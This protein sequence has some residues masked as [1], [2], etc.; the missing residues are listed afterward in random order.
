M[1]AGHPPGPIPPGQDSAS[2]GFRHAGHAPAPAGARPDLFVMRKHLFSQAAPSAGGAHEAQQEPAVCR[3]P[4]GHS[5]ANARPGLAATGRA[6]GP[7]GLPRFPV[8]APTGNR[9][10][11]T[12]A[13]PE[14]QNTRKPAEPQ[15]ADTPET[16]VFA[17]ATTPWPQPDR[18]PAQRSPLCGKKTRLVRIIEHWPPARGRG[19]RS[20]PRS[21]WPGLAVHVTPSM[22][23]RACKTGRRPGPGAA[24]GF[25]QRRDAARGARASGGRGAPRR[26][27]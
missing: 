6:A 19:K 8:Y 9:H 20:S 5:A 7:S 12:T 17:P 18:F 26:C 22:S 11:A 1:F 27:G 23:R 15:G 24:R 14:R 4:G 25:P 21:R 16:C 3:P 10:L 13:R 2:A